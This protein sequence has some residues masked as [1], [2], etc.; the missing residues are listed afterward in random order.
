MARESKTVLAHRRWHRQKTRE[1]IIEARQP[2]S[3]SGGLSEVIV[4]RDGALSAVLGGELSERH[5]P[6]DP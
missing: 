1:A 5:L 4:D 2:G 3:E 6:Q